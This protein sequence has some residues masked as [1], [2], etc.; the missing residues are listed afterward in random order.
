V[1]GAAEGVPVD[2][3]ARRL[4]TGDPGVFGRIDRDRVLLDLRT[5]LPEDDAA[6]AGAVR[7]GL[8]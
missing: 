5:I 4:R 8:A 2:A 6:L 1:L 7:R 3:L